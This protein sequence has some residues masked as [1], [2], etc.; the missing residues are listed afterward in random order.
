EPAVFTDHL[1]LGRTGLSVSPSARAPFCIVE[2]LGVP[3][4]GAIDDRNRLAVDPA[5]LSQSVEKAARSGEGGSLRG[6][7]TR[8]PRRGIDAAAWA[9]PKRGPKRGPAAN[10]TSPI[11]RISIS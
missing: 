10:K 2:Q 1:E 6:A 11:K 3:F 8:Y 7:S 5:Q 9:P 4:C